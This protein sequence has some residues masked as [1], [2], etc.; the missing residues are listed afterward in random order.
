MRPEEI[1]Q[2]HIDHALV[3]G[4]P[5]VSD[6]GHVCPATHNDGSSSDPNA[7][8][9][10]TH[11]QLDPAVTSTRSRS[12]PGRRRSPTRMQ[13][14]GMYLRDNGGSFVVYAENPVSRGYDAWSKAGLPGGD[15]VSLNGIPWAKLRVVSPPAC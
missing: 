5:G 3:F 12:R 10:G 14:Y 13:T 15:S 6:L 7:P 1:V 8:M 9:E 2:G 4:M 11:L